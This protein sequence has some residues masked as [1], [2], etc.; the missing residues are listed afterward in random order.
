MPPRILLV[1]SFLHICGKRSTII[2]VLSK[3][4]PCL[5]IR[6]V[7]VACAVI[8]D[9]S[10]YLAVQRSPE[11]RDPGLWEFPGGKVEPGENVFTC[12]HRELEEELGIGVHICGALRSQ[13]VMIGERRILLHPLLCTLNGGH[14]ELKEHSDARWLPLPE[15]AQ[16]P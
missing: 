10:L 3:R 15:L 14:F 6:N 2:R 1:H 13:A 5:N 12:L 8:R 9:G 11:M 16:L 4:R 7:P